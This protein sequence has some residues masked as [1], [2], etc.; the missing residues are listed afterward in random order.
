MGIFKKSKRSH[1]KLI[2]FF[3][4]MTGKTAVDYRLP[5]VLKNYYYR[6]FFEE[7][8]VFRQDVDR[9]ISSGRIDIYNITCM[10]NRIKHICQ[11]ALTDVDEQHINRRNVIN[12]IIANRQAHIKKLDTQIQE[13]EKSIQLLESEIAKED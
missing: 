13:I 3:H 2:P 9:F 10:D 5:D 1:E 11:Q 7:K 8:S 12:L 4:G 6:R